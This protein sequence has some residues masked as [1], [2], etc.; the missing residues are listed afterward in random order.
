MPSAIAV[1]FQ[2]V[3]D[4]RQR[5]EPADLGAVVNEI[6]PDMLHRPRGLHRREAA[7]PP[8]QRIEQS[9]TDQRT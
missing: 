9:E 5:K 1:I 6:A 4:Q 2:I 8:D 3:M 7:V